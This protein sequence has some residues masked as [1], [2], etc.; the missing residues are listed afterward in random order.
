MLVSTMYVMKAFRELIFHISTKNYW[1]AQKQRR[2]AQTL[3]ALHSMHAPAA[4]CERVLWYQHFI[5][6]LRT[7]HRA[8]ECLRDLSDIARYELKSLMYHDL[9]HTATCLEL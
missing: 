1:Q 9:V 5:W 2:V 6:D 7:E 3:A 4:L 8:H